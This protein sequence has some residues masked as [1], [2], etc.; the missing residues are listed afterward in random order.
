MS[1]QDFI[2]LYEKCLAGKCTDE[3]RALLESYYAE[4][5]LLDNEWDDALG[6]E[7][8]TREKIKEKMRLG[9]DL[10][11]VPVFKK[12]ALF[13]WMGYA[14]SVLF[15]IT[16]GLLGWYYLTKPVV[17][18][19]AAGNIKPG[20]NMAYLTLANGRS[21]VL[22]YAKNGQIAAGSGII[23]KKI[24]DS[25]LSYSSN[26]NIKNNKKIQVAPD[27][28]AL[29]IP[30]GGIFQTVLSDGTKVWLN[31]A[32]SL[33]YPVAFAGKER[34][35][36]LVGEAY[37]EVAKNKAM[38][39]KVSVKG[40][41]VQVLGTH[42]NVMGYP[43]EKE[44]KTTLLE[45]AVKLHSTAGN[46]LLRPGQQGVYCCP[47]ANFAINE[48]NT[49]DVVAWK[50]GFFVFDNESIQNTMMKIGRWYNV[51][52]VFE[53]KL[54]HSSFGGTI[55]RYKNIDVVLKALEATG[56][57]HFK[58]AGRRVVVMN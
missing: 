57:V 42:F 48:V 37:F 16:A 8:E 33:K 10:Q 20:K 40:V 55:S 56:S 2:T 51:D 14:A 21:I 27:S 7:D 44:V 49:A 46:A 24:N 34:R 19:Q 1:K 38:P 15:L 31:S 43:E 52:I 9:A 18:N 17:N 23:I 39:F 25:I 5:K 35:V 41:D 53:S 45:G 11:L 22:H 12:S 26:N 13:T 6:D 28:N 32:S 30:R 4:I 47:N 36:V 29:T 54:T 58:I 3:E 50:D